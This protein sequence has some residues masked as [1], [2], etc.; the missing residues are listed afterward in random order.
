MAKM[1]ETDLVTLLDAANS[2]SVAFSGEFN[3]ASEQALEYYMGMPFGD[4]EEGRS[5]LISTDVQDVVEADMPSLARTFLG[6]SQVMKFTPLSDKPED[7]KE[8]DQKTKYVNWLIRHQPESFATLHGWM[9]S[10][11]IQKISVVKYFVEDT[12][13][14]T[15]HEFTGLS[16]FE[17][18]ALEEDLN[19]EDVKSVDIAETT[20]PEEDG[21]FDI[22]FRV[23]KGQQKLRICG[24]RLDNFRVSR[25][26]TSLEDAELVGD[27][28]ILTRGELLSQGF[29]RKQ[30]SEITRIGADQ[31]E[32]NQSQL[33][34]VTFHD[35]N[36]S[37]DSDG[38]EITDWAS[39]EILIENRY[40][41]IDFDDDGIAERRYVRKSGQIVLVNEPF[42][43]V[44]Y[45]ALSAI[46]MPHKL[47]GRSRAELV[48]ETQ[49]AKSEMLRGAADNTYMVNNPRNLADEN[50]NIDEL[51]DVIAYGTVQVKGEGTAASSIFPLTV[52]FVADKAIM[53]LNYLDQQRAN[54]T[55]ALATSQS[56]N[57]DDLNQETAT[58]FTGIEKSGAEKVE[59]VA[60]VFAETGWAK[61]FEGVAWMVGRF[62]NTEV[63]VM[64]LG[65]QLTV[66][67]TNWKF[68][69]HVVSEVGL[70]ISD[71]E[72]SVQTLTG[73][74]ADQNILK[75]EGSTL[76]DD[77]KRYNVRERLIKA[78]GL[79]SIRDFYNDPE[80][81]EET[82]LAENEVMRQ[83]LEL[84]GQQLQASANPLAEAEAIKREGDIA[85]ARG[86]LS[87]DAAKLQADSQQADAQLILDQRKQLSDL[88]IKITELELQ[89]GKDLSKQVED[90]KQV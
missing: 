65:E 10:A 79:G 4:E 76:V 45:A 80:A 86:K 53:M 71:N 30:I 63:E 15:E 88:A 84:M 67:P 78:T 83:Q 62:Q 44:P 13:K 42:D 87:L 3:A 52:P 59:L 12:L 11:E 49:R 31:N 9:K 55:G 23:T 43:H 72:E 75:A 20:E 26:A 74:M 36:D 46:L 21:K 81:P 69:H 24:I 8:A 90:N 73:I 32:N 16:D 29:T 82:L 19:D 85:I 48:M 68:D 33:K 54:R 17:A 34:D 66:D 56:L 14:T 1:K 5:S 22:T 39:E 18:V 47:I 28:E 6:S 37:D 41:R 35:E 25:F 64:V 58:R 51:N 57:A 38:N 77:K 50:V 7:E 70:A 2:D 40:V 89:A 60:R 61:L 27:D